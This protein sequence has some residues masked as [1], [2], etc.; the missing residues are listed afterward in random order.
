MHVLGQTIL[1]LNFFV[2]NMLMLYINF[3]DHKGYESH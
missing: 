2:L 1:S 3:A